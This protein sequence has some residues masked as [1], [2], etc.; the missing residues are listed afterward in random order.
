MRGFR[1]QSEEDFLSESLTNCSFDW[2]MLPDCDSVKDDRIPVVLSGKNKLLGIP[3][4][5]STW[6]SDGKE[7]S[8][9]VG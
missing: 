4:L 2:K 5:H 6:K 7:D 3:H 1:K 8:P 9:Y